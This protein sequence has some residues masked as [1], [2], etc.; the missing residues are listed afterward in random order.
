MPSLVRDG[1]KPQYFMVSC[2]DSRSNPGTLF[3]AAPGTFFSH[4]AM[5]AIVRPYQKGTALSAGL[6]F[7]IH[8][9]QVKDIIVLGHTSCGAVKALIENIDDDEISSFIS[10]AREGVIRAEDKHACAHNH[11]H[12]H[13]HTEEEIILLSC[14]N[15]KGYP[16]VSSALKKD[17]IRIHG[18]LFDMEHGALLE[19]K[20]ASGTFEPII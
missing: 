16:A 13:R 12:L 17:S 20:N 10:V 19:Y 5:G 18:W 6:Q 1:Q 3:N 15:L 4:K 11:D 2:I 8:H 14:E 7:A 9:N